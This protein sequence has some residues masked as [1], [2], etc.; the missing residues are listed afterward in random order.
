MVP[1]LILFSF[2]NFI[3]SSLINL[4]DNV[5][6]SN[7]HLR[8]LLDL[9]VFLGFPPNSENSNL[10]FFDLLNGCFIKKK[11]SHKHFISGETNVFFSSLLKRK[12]NV[13]VKNKS[14]LIN[15]LLEYYG[16]HLDGFFVKSHK[17]LEDVLQK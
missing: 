11:P 15:A 12:E 6:D 13:K 7:M 5:F 3:R 16:L 8:F 17:I 9:S 10:P 14:E 2:P 1:T 4:D